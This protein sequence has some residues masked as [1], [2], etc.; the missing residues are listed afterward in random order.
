MTVLNNEDWQIINKNYEPHSQHHFIT[1]YIYFRCTAM[2]EF[3]RM[4][5]IGVANHVRDNQ[6]DTDE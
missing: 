4:T 1:Q 2:N 5:R 3:Y 6:I